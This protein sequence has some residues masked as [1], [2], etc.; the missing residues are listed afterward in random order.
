MLNIEELKEYG[1][2]ITDAM[3]KG[4]SVIDIYTEIWENLSL[5]QEWC[6]PCKFVSPI[7]HKLKDEGLIHLIATDLDQNRPLGQR[8]GITAI[9]TILFFKNG[10]M[11]NHPIE[12]QGQLLVRNGMMIGAVGEPIL[13]EIIGKIEAF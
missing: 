1:L 9:P 5:K 2:E 8:F 6:G 12:V 3:K 13:R 11:L 7:L 10:E 4:I